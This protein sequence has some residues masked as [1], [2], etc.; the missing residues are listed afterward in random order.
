M[1]PSAR[2]DGRHRRVKALLSFP[3]R[4]ES[5]DNKSHCLMALFPPPLSPTPPEA[6][7]RSWGK[8]KE[9]GDTPDS[10]SA[11]GGH[12]P[13]SFLRKQ[14]SRRMATCAPFHA[15]PGP[16]PLYPPLAKGEQKPTQRGCAPVHAPLRLSSPSTGED[17][18]VSF[19]HQTPCS[20][21]AMISSWTTFSN[22]TKKALYPTTR[23][24]RSL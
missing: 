22:S 8:S 1:R 14:E 7:L 6:H 18:G 16:I 13:L 24:T 15:T 11:S 9:S 20:V 4:R 5:R 17:N 12:S 3:Q 10:R 2:P 23:T 21:L 19:T